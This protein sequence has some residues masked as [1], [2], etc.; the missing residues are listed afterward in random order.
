MTAASPQPL[1]PMAG[2]FEMVEH[3]PGSA[4]RGIVTRITGYREMLRGYTRQ[5][6]CASLTIP[7]IISFG[8]PFAIGLGRDPGDNDRYGSFAAGLFAGPVVIDSFGA[9][10]CLQVD[11]TP[12]GARRFFGLPM[13][14]LANCMLPLDDVLGHA[15]AALRERLGNTPGWPARFAIAEHFVATRVLAGPPTAPELRLAYGRIEATGG[16]IPVSRLAKAAGWSRKHLAERFR[17]EFGI[18]PKAVSRI[19]RFDRAMREARAGA[20]GWADIAAGCGF[21]DQA[22]MTREFQALAGLPPTAWQAGL[23]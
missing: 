22:H 19:V 15:G 5:R 1:P 10:A 6:E 14:E 21:A 17:A 7:L 3:R 8:E 11:F 23:A 2:T 4:L 20:A 18:G 13:H 16:Q 12:L 9:A